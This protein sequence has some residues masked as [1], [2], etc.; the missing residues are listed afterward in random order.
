MRI[1]FANP[2]LQDP[3]DSLDFVSKKLQ[4]KQRRRLAEQSRKAQQRRAHR[5]NN[6]ITIGIAVVVVAGV[7]AVI[8]KDR[9]STSS[10]AEG[11]APSEAHCNGIQ[12]FP[13]EGHQHVAPPQTVTYK[14]NPPTSGNHYGSPN[15]PV[16]PGFYTIDAAPPVEAVVHNLEHGQIVFWY[17]PDAPGDV[18]SAIRAM[19]QQGDAPRNLPARSVPPLVAVAW[20][21]LPNPYNFGMSA[22]THSESCEQFSREVVDAFR[23]RFQGKG[24]E[25]LGVPTFPPTTG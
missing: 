21:Q 23:R 13:A 9:I 4:E 12:T 3:T 16:A 1:C 22:W 8:V 7:A 19:V 6:L 2:L 10:A 24:R 15:G 17:R 25:Q 14:T 11:V 20:P 5:R 18:I